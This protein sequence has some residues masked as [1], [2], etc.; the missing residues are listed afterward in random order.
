LGGKSIIEARV[1]AGI[2]RARFAWV[3][4]VL[5]LAAT[6]AIGASTANARG[7][8]TGFTDDL[9]SSSSS[10][11]RGHWL[12]RA[13]DARSGIIRISVNWRD[14]VGSNPPATPANPADPAYNFGELDGAVRSARARGLDVMLT[15]YRAPS[16]AEG[17]KPPR[18]VHPGTWKPD[19]SKLGQFGTALAR[20]YSG[21]YGALPRVKYFEAWTEPNL[22]E[23]LAPQWKRDK[24][25]SPGI[26]RKMLNAFYD[27]VKAGQPGAKVIGG[28]TAPYGDAAG[29][30]RMRPI[31]F[32]RNLFCLD[33]DFKA[34]KC[35]SK[36]HLDI[37][38]HHPINF[39]TNPHYKAFSRNDAPTA[40]FNRVKRV[41]RAAA[42]TKHVR[43]KGRKPLWATEILWYTDPPTRF[44]V[45]VNKEARWLEDALYL[46]WK[47]GASVVINFEIRDLPYDPKRPRLPYSGVFFEN[48]KPKPAYRAWRF[49]FVT[50]RKSKKRVLA[51]GKA[52]QSGKLKIQKKKGHGH[53]RNI[54]GLNV[55]NGK[56]F[57]RT[58]RLKGNATLRAKLGK[59]T[60]LTWHQHN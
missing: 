42:K 38:S 8:T 4:T 35:P 46:L 12:D 40:N 33:H 26:Y 30:V 16:W 27:G 6:A 7:L 32:L 48:G 11:E 29:G 1:R 9:F 50:H 58:V 36:P 39:F 25:K 60:S 52:P 20:R 21:H 37:L 2:R 49:P 18:S 55:R 57:K 59:S 28:A 34:N 17:A 45:P 53:W 54:K 51:W 56:V 41:M 19:P 44:G 10:A 47:Q 24:A 3:V 14:S 22:K 13:V 43:P 15:V 23:Y 5:A 31:T